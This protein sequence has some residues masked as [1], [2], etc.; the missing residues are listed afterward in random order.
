MRYVLKR[1][2]LNNIEYLNTHPKFSAL[3]GKNKYVTRTI[4]MGASVSIS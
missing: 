1:K 3:Y 2:N 4:F